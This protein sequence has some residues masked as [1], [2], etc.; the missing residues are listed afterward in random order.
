MGRVAD[1]IPRALDIGIIIRYIN[2]HDKEG[3]SDVEKKSTESN[4]SYKMRI[5][6]LYIKFT[7]T[8]RRL[9]KANGSNDTLPEMPCKY[10]PHGG[11]VGQRETKRS[12]MCDLPQNVSTKRQPHTQNLQCALPLCVRE[13]KRYVEV[14]DRVNRIK[15]LGNAIVP[16]VAYQIMKGICDNETNT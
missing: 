6:L 13:A 14:G 4:T 10:R 16:Q 2:D 11:Q 5:L 8:P 7:A 15:G 3:K 1:G 9:D 12:K